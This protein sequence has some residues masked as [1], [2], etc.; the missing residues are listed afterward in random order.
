MGKVQRIKE[1]DLSL[2]PTCSFDL[3]CTN[4]SADFGFVLTCAV[5]PF[6][7]PAKVLRIDQ[8]PGYKQDRSNDKALVKA[9]ADELVK[10]AIAIGYNSVRYDIP[11]LISR[12]LYHNLDTRPLQTIKHLD[13]IFA[14]RHRMR[15]RANSLAV[16][17]E[18]FGTDE[19]K[20]P[21]VGRIW[22]RAAT[23]DK[24][25]LDAIVRHNVADVDVLEEITK[26]MIHLIDIKFQLIR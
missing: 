14:A 20:T 6:G 21:L 10:Y 18:H 11:F 12:M 22:S 15:L 25:A 24:K 1:A 19:R 2:F 7:R 9:I 13:L 17:Q 23:G 3:E 4:L 16:V 5:K 8:F 26:R